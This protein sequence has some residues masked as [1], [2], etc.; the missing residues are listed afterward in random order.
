[1]VHIAPASGGAAAARFT[2]AVVPPLHC[3][4][5]IAGSYLF[6]AMPGVIAATSSPSYASVDC[7]TAEQGLTSDVVIQIPRPRGGDTRPTPRTVAGGLRSR[8]TS[9]A[10]HIRH[11]A[12]L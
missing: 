4:T 12:R 7:S 10:R 3:A 6:I 8:S 9:G 1:V 2:I 11:V 5:A